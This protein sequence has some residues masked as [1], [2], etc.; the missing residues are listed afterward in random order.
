MCTL[1]ECLSIESS[2]MG[3]LGH[4]ESEL[5]LPECERDD[6]WLDLSPVENAVYKERYLQIVNAAKALEQHRQR[7]AERAELEQERDGGDA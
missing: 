3:C 6:R 5:E 2:N 1:N 4:A 7:R